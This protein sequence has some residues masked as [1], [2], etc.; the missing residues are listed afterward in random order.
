MAGESPEEELGLTMKITL[1]TSLNG[2]PMEPEQM[3]GLTY[4]SVVV[5]Q[6]ICD[7]NRRRLEFSTQ[8]G[9]IM[10]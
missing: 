7:I 10:V 4:R 9:Q 3:K 1:K 8:D 2:V 6:V 5:S